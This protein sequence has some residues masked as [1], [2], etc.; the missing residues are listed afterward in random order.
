MTENEE[1][2]LKQ[3]AAHKC[4]SLRHASCAYWNG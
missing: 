1:E 3:Q 2:A 4:H